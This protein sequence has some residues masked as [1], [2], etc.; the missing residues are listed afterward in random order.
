MRTVWRTKKEKKRNKTQEQV[1][2]EA[3]PNQLLAAEIV[4]KYW[5]RLNVLAG[6]PHYRYAFHRGTHKSRVG[7]PGSRIAIYMKPVCELLGMVNLGKLGSGNYTP[8]IWDGE[9]GVRYTRRL[10]ALH[11]KN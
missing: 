1:V 10:P 6:H 9:D 11:E 8:E 2:I 7:D 5:A 4:T 3:T